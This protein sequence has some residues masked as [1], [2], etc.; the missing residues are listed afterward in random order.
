MNRV[1]RAIVMAEGQEITVADLHLGTEATE[2]AVRDL[3]TAR[4]AAERAAIAEALQ[5]A[6]GQAQRAAQLLGVSRATLYRLIAQHRI[7]HVE[8]P[9]SHS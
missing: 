8:A 9:L 7:P 2:Q 5:R 1:R 6:Q 3:E 4:K